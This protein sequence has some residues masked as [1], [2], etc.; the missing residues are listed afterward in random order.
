MW[1][2]NDRSALRSFH[3]LLREKE[4]KNNARLASQ[5]G[6]SGKEMG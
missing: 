6:R 2:R 3:F 4:K 5:K 1:H